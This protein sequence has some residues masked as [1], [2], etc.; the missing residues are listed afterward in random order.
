[1]FLLT[2]HQMTL[3]VDLYEVIVTNFSAIFI[4]LSFTFLTFSDLNDKML[5]STKYCT[6]NNLF[7]GLFLSC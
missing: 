2:F 7:I 6:K 3:I 4:D 5:T 1:M